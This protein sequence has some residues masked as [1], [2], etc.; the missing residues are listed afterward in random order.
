MLIVHHL[1]RSQSER[2]VWLCEELHLPY[3][4]RIHKRDVK[5]FQSP[6]ELKALHPT[7]AAPIIQDGPLTLAESGAIVEYILTL[8]DPSRTLSLPPAD[9]DYPNY[10]YFLHF[11]NGYFQPALLRYGPILRSGGPAPTDVG[12]GFAKKAFENA[13]RI[14][15]D[16]VK[17]VEWLAG[18]KFTA[19][20]VMVVTTLTTVRV[21]LPYSLKGYEGILG[22]LKRVGE[23]AGF[24]RAREKGDPGADMCLGEEVV[25]GGGVPQVG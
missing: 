25:R 2:I 1:Q 22:Y 21:W 24:R 6:P 9:P 16:R 5:T 17:Q 12:A 15:D 3:D 20:D 8:Y 23:R 4:L 10:L 14:L 13:L 18:D 7:G 11:A 19:A